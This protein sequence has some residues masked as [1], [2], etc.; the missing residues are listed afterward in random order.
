MANYNSTY[1]T[2]YFTVTDEAKYK[3]LFSRLTGEDLEDFS[4]VDNNGPYHGFGGYNGTY[5]DLD[6]SREYDGDIEDF[7]E[8]LSKILPEDDA[9]IYTEVGNNKLQH[10]SGYS[11]VATKKEGVKCVD[12]YDAAKNLAKECLEKDD[13]TTKMEY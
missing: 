10:V 11:L 4:G 2:N 9:V 8:D 5:Y 7:L 12:L 6:G 13:Y 3:E 1:R